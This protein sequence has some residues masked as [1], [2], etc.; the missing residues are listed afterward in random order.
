MN[1][2]DLG[3]WVKK[4][5]TPQ[6]VKSSVQKQP[7]FLE[8]VQ[9]ILMPTPQQV[10]Q[11]WQSIGQNVGKTLQ[12]VNY[13]P[14]V[15]VTNPV[16]RQTTSV[17][18]PFQWQDIPLKLGSL[19]VQGYGRDIER[20]S[21]PALRKQL[22][23]T[24]I[25]GA[26]Q[27]K[28]GKILEALNQPGIETL[29][30][31]TDF[32]PGGIIASTASRG[33]KKAGLFA[34]T[35]LKTDDVKRVLK[36]VIGE[37]P[38]VK[39][40]RIFTDMGLPPNSQKVY[41]KI[42]KN[43][44]YADQAMALKKAISDNNTWMKEEIPL[45]PFEAT[46]ESRAAITHFIKNTNDYKDF[47]NKAEEA[48]PGSIPE[49]NRWAKDVGFENLSS[50]YKKVKK[51]ITKFESKSGLLSE[52]GLSVKPIEKS[53]HDIMGPNI[54]RER[55][56]ALLK[57]GGTIKT[58]EELK[59]LGKLPETIKSIKVAGS[60]FKNQLVNA[61]SLQGPKTFDISKTDSIDY[62]LDKLGEKRVK[63]IFVESGMHFNETGGIK[64]FWDMVKQDLN[65]K[66]PGWKLDEKMADL[67]LL[68]DEAAEAIQTTAKTVTK[69]I[70]IIADKSKQAIKSLSDDIESFAVKHPGKSSVM[71]ETA[72]KA[73][74]DLQTHASSIVDRISNGIKHFNI[75]QEDFVKYIE[76]PELA[77]R[78]VQDLV[79]A[80]RRLMEIAHGTRE[81]IELG[82]LENYYPHMS[83]EAMETGSALKKIGDNL[84][85]SIFNTELGSGIKRT[86]K[87]TDYSKDYRKVM[88][89]YFEQVAFDK[90]GKRVGLT[91]RVAEFVGKLEK[92]L[93][94]NK[95][96]VMEEA[97]NTFDY[98]EESAKKADIKKRT[99]VRSN[100]G[101]IDTFDSLRRKIQNELGDIP[102]VKAMGN[103][104]DMYDNA[105]G[106]IV[107]MEKMSPS[108]KIETL[109]SELTSYKDKKGLKAILLNATG[110]G[111]RDIPAVLLNNLLHN[112]IAIKKQ[113]FIDLIGKYDF[114]KP[115]LKYLNTEIDRLMKR[116][117]MEQSLLN[118]AVNFVTSTFYKAQI[119]LNVN[120]GIAQRLESTRI[121]V[122]YDKNVISDGV[123]QFV[124]DQQAGS[125]ILK[126]YD[127]SGVE[128][129]ISKQLG[130]GKVGKIKDTLSEKVGEGINKLGNIFVNIGENSKNR[131]F[132]YA[133]EAQGK[134]MGL[135]GKELY[136]FVRNE[137][138]ANGF[139]LHEFN[140][141]K[142]LKN[143]LVRLAL[144]Y[145]QYN[146]KL[147]NRV[148]EM[149]GKDQKAKAAGLVG[150]QVFGLALLMGITGKSL[151]VIKDRL[152]L[153]LGPG[154]TIPYQIAG[155]LKEQYDISQ[156]EKATGVG[157]ENKSEKINKKL[158]KLA[159]RNT[160]PAGNQFFKTKDALDVLLK[161]YDETN[162]GL[163]SYM[164]PE[165]KLDQGR[166]LL[167]GKTSF[168]EN[169]EYYKDGYGNPLGK[170][171]T[172]Y[173]KQEGASKD[174]YNEIMQERKAENK[175]EAIKESMKREGNK[176]FQSGNFIYIKEGD[177]IVTYD[178]KNKEHV[179]KLATKKAKKEVQETGE[180]KQVD[181]TIYYKDSTDSKIKSINVVDYEKK[182]ADAEYAL[183]ADRL[184]RADDYKGWLD[185]TKE[186]ISALQDWANKL[187]SPYEEA[188]R[189]RVQNKIEDLQAQVD[190]YEGY[191]GF[192]KGKKPAKVTLR[193]ISIP[194]VSNIKISTPKL[195]KI[196]MPKTPKISNLKIK[197]PK[198]ILTN[199]K[200]KSIKIKSTKLA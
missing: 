52:L 153:Q 90:Y 13:N 55:T 163:V 172:A 6:Q 97:G 83:D 25:K 179:K 50:M 195:A 56:D 8:R 111:K 71:G 157:M 167:F 43:E 4:T 48:I 57:G 104:R 44:R 27:L 49:L 109:L 122:L 17:A 129:D 143:P 160:I 118:S 116:G 95:D 115:T 181:N 137:L 186:H 178:M 194:K 164:A 162:S 66:V 62:I 1:L 96:G 32:I 121:P 67:S 145:Q 105:A 16:T 98:I 58:Q 134:R 103:V 139:I 198:N 108:Q 189:T 12:K 15:Q 154:V 132:L 38:E 125:D 53:V 28:Q 166:G 93:T 165:N 191:G 175:H 34:K 102:I 114:D 110:N 60:A 101:Y 94:P 33:I 200:N 7:S 68:T 10:G 84:W 40:F 170:N 107:R 193:K 168:P 87:M 196:K 180:A 120:T 85:I 149:V 147:I 177:D 75:S 89:N 141:P 76:N 112:E 187:N 29:L 117:Q 11:R 192:K 86:G 77:P 69:P 142:M 54:W 106:L 133:A 73:Y 46:K 148:F 80:H 151:E 2:S 82:K 51:E 161:G 127:F 188:E 63:Q 30:D 41:S 199:T 92:H 173:F 35:A 72:N 130:Y 150:A 190:K 144:Q 19:V 99:F 23:P 79:S 21:T 156:E 124:K 9:S 18:R 91:P 184:K 61:F 135:Q 136:T 182:V 14:Q 113:T 3:N 169:Q 119:W 5:I 45:K 88:S 24:A 152:K 31:M 123:K 158:S 146:I 183:A 185:K 126:R 47:L 64:K 70:K 171:Q 81:N 78:E 159:L 59:A 37:T 42:Y 22:V 138:F 26:Q 100:M 65:T 128:T 174:V 140:T 176:E 197:K 131:D 155:L 36:M 20:L 74:R 39:R